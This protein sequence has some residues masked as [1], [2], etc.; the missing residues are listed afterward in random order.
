MTASV[1]GLFPFM[2]VSI[3]CEEH[4]SFHHWND[5]MLFEAASLGHTYPLPCPATTNT[6]YWGGGGKP[7]PWSTNWGDRQ[8]G[9][10]H[11]VN[12]YPK[13]NLHS[14]LCTENKTTP[15]KKNTQGL[16]MLS[17]PATFHAHR[18]ADTGIWWFRGGMGSVANSRNG[19]GSKKTACRYFFSLKKSFKI[20][21][22]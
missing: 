22:Q 14:E 7:G 15:P 1:L 19:A 6:S 4:H 8:G 18:L 2:E 13:W 20:R 9:S 17:N 5:E 11:F 12:Q 16:E 10:R 3:H 21:P